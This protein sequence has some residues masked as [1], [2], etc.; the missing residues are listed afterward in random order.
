MPNSAD[1]GRQS[2][3]LRSLSKNPAIDFAFTRHAAERMMQRQVTKLD[4][5]AALR[6]GRVIDAGLREGETSWLAAGDDLDGRALRIVVV[7]YPSE[8]VIK[9]VT[10]YEPD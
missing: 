3:E 4:V 10:V 6:N 2:S 1:Y 5:L 7:P 9:V 8:N